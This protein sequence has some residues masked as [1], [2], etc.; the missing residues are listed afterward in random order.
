MKPRLR[1]NYYLLYE[2]P[3]SS[4]EEALTVLSERRR[5]DLKGRFLR[6]FTRYVVPL[7]DGSHEL[8]EIRTRV[9]DVFD[10]DDLDAAL[11]L[12]G[13]QRLLEYLDDDPAVADAMRRSAPQANYVHELGADA[14]AIAQALARMRVT[15]VGAGS[16]GAA[17]AQA[18]VAAGARTLHVV[19]ALTV[20]PQDTS[21]G[22][23]YALADVG[24]PRADALR[25]RLA[26][27]AP[28]V[29]VSAA[30]EP[31]ADDDATATAI[32]G[33]DFVV[34]CVDAADVATSFR[35]NRVCA[36]LGIPWLSAV[37]RGFEVLVGPTVEPG[38]G[39]CFLC[40]TMRGVACESDPYRAFAQQS[41]F[42]RRERDD[43]DRRENVAFGIGLAANLAGLEI[44]NRVCGLPPATRGAVL[45]FDLV[46]LELDRYTVLRKPDCPVCFPRAPDA[47]PAQTP[48]YSAT[49]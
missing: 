35:L 28:D 9:A 24:R 27:S 17:L 20:R 3:D 2:P 10:P 12:L 16:L 1:T 32:A 30:A 38:G 49:R 23:A 14:K 48:A 5:I 34:A 37:A 44:F 22:A 33:S 19:D 46:K 18:L 41:F 21:L 25:D 11:E 36:A 26:Q 43:S 40:A 4:G 47:P 42:D 15:I 13:Q 7:L 8:D 45:V 29:T 6:E 31:P 39:A